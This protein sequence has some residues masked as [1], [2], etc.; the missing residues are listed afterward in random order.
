MVALGKILL[1]C[2]QFLISHAKR[3]ASSVEFQ[4]ARSSVSAYRKPCGVSSQTPERLVH[5]APPVNSG[6]RAK[7]LKKKV[8]GQV[9]TFKVVL[10]EAEVDGW[11]ESTTSTFP[12]Y[13]PVT[14]GVQAKKP[15]P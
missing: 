10:C 1:A 13:V 6:S 4:P 5:T 2:R 12:V 14:V 7:L 15:V 3:S 9:T 11:A 8:Q